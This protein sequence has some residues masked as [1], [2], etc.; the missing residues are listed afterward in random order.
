MNTVKHEVW[1]ATRLAKENEEVRVLVVDDNA[2]GRGAIAAYLTLEGMNARAVA[3]CAEA[4]TVSAGWK[5][6]IAVL[7]IMMPVQDGFETAQALR[8]RF[9]AG[10]LIVAFTAT[11][12]AFVKAHPD[13]F[14]LFD[15]YCQ[16]GT[17]PLHLIRVLESLLATTARRQSPA[18]GA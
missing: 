12:S 17:S 18:R 16:K 7:D 14:R 11:D 6:D 1:G 2:S 8:A 10:L 13:S 5:P 9:D 15:G 3:S 4:L